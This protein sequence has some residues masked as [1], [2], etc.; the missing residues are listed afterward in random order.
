MVG[1]VVCNKQRTKEVK[2]SDSKIVD[3]KQA[4]IRIGKRFDDL[5]C[6]FNGIIVHHR[7]IMFYS[8]ERKKGHGREAFETDPVIDP[9]IFYI[10]LVHQRDIRQKQETVS[11]FQMICFPVNG[12]SPLAV[13]D[14]VK[15]IIFDDALGRNMAGARLLIAALKN[16][17][18]FLGRK[19]GVKIDH[20]L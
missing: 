13:G 16:G 12:I 2:L 5:R 3:R 9:G 11:F 18:R 14:A 15:D 4:G 1:V 7:G 6:L 17:N 20:P 10:G 8:A 19:M